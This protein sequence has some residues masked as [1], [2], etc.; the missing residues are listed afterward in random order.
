MRNQWS[1]RRL[2]ASSEFVGRRYASIRG[3]HEDSRGQFREEPFL[4]FFVDG[5][6]SLETADGGQ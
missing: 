1:H 6:L 2:E 3:R 4:N 5:H